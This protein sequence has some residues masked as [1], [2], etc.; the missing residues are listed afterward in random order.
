MIGGE[1]TVTALRWLMVY[2][3]HWPQIQTDCYNEIIAAV[4]DK[5]YPELDDQPSLP[6]CMASIQEMLRLSGFAPLGI[7]HK[8]S[9]DSSIAGMSIPKNTEL[10]FNLWAIGHDEREHVDPEIFKPQRWLDENGKFDPKRHRSFLIFST[11]RRGCLGENL[12]R[13]ELFYIFTRLLRDF[14]VEPNKEEKFPSLRGVT[15]GTLAPHPF[16]IVFTPRN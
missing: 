10:F 6:L 13:K 12:A 3:L 5:R 7:P 1:T 8:S 4:G 2:L 16:K 9:K 15:G 14:V 11:G